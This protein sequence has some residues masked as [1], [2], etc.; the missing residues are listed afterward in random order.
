MDYAQYIGLPFLDKGRTIQ[1]V[2]CWGLVR[3]ILWEQFCIEVPSYSEDYIT[4]TDKAE[5]SALIN[6]ESLGMEPVEQG[7]AR[8]GDILVLRLGGR[9]WH[10][11]LVIDPPWFLH[12]DPHAGVVRERMDGQLWTHRVLGVYRHPHLMEHRC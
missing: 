5:V 8:P 11:A 4:S 3:L 9:P 10:C 1:G 7:A 2:D 6:Q 12:A